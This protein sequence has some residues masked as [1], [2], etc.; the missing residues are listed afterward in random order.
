MNKT[1]ETKQTVIGHIHLRV[2]MERKS[3]YVRAAKPGKLNDWLIRVLDLAAGFTR[4]FHKPEIAVV[5]KGGCVVGVYS[6]DCP[7]VKVEILDCDGTDEIGP[8]LDQDKADKIENSP[9]W[10]QEIARHERLF[11][12]QVERSLSSRRCGRRC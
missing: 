9:E 3:A 10:T 1:P 11:F 2:P 8:E 7:S 5:V 12:N 6:K 4:E